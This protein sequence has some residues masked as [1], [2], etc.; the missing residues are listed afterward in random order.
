MFH[1]IFPIK[2]HFFVSDYTN[3]NIYSYLCKIIRYVCN[4]YL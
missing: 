1:F 3:N 2:L 4:Y